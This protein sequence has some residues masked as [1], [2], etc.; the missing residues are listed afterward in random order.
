M[1][2]ELK[3]LP[4]TIIT[5]ENFNEVARAVLSGASFVFGGG[6]G[7]GPSGYTRQFQHQDWIDFVDPVQASGNNGF[8]ERFHA[9]EQEFN[10]IS[11]AI[12]SVDDA[13]T[14][15]QAAPPAIGLTVVVG[16]SDGATIPVPA[17]F[18][19]AETRFFAFVKLYTVDLSTSGTSI[20]FRVF[21][22]N[23]G[24]VTAKLSGTGT[25]QSLLATGIG[26]AKKGGW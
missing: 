20:G 8:N 17:G 24:V 1:P 9:L 12:S 19:L 26:I 21:T 2:D 23:N 13:V 3:I 5:R 14:N 25:G 18:Q 6:G 16:I 7:G 11:G 10:L 4:G 15:L 22:D